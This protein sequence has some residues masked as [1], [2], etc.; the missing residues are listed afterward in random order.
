MDPAAPTIAEPRRP[1]TPGSPPS[2]SPAASSPRWRWIRSPAS[3]RVRGCARGR[4]RLAGRPTAARG[5]AAGSG[6]ASGEQDATVKVGTAAFAASPATRPAATPSSGWARPRTTRSVPR[7]ASTTCSRP[8]RRRNCAA[9]TAPSTAAW[10]GR[11][12]TKGV[13]PALGLSKTP[14]QIP[15]G[16][17]AY[18]LASHWVYGATLEACRRIAAATSPP[19]TPRQTSSKEPQ[20]TDA[21]T[22]GRGVG[23]RR[24][25]LNL[26]AVRRSAPS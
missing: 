26:P 22:A 12:P 23:D 5:C 6:D 24:R 8:R 9:A 4:R 14:D 10:C 1:S 19:G 21:P 2:A 25:Q 7:W 16:V 17:H 18:A 13:L 15:L 3:A 11:P 20:T